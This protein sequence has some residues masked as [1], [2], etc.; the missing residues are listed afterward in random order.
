M[1]LRLIAQDL[2]KFWIRKSL[3]LHQIYG[4]DN[5]VRDDTCYEDNKENDD[6]TSLD[7]IIP[8]EENINWPF[9]STTNSPT[10]DI[11]SDQPPKFDNYIHIVEWEE[12]I[13]HTFLIL[14]SKDK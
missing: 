10:T 5:F 2:E 6:S 4:F 7:N 8:L 12:V 11:D 9:R 14:W 3:P 1:I 13:L